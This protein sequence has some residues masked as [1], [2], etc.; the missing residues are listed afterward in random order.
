MRKEFDACRELFD[1][2]QRIVLSTHVNPDPDA[3]GSEIALAVYLRSRGKEVAILNHS[4]TPANCLFLDRLQSIKQFD[5]TLHAGIIANAD[6]IVVLDANQP[7]RIQSLRPFVDQSTATKICIDHH[8]E[9]QPFA[10]LYVV[11]EEAAATGEI[12]FNLLLYC[13]PG[14]ITE[15]IATALYA[16]IMTDTGSF[17]FPKTDADLHRIIAELIERGADPASIF[18]ET[19]EQGSAKRLQLLGNV[20]STLK[21]A[22]DGKV[23]SVFVTRAMF[24]NTGTTEED[25]ENFVTYALTIAGVE[26]AL[27]F[28]ELPDGIKIS[29]RS[30][31]DIAVNKLA[32][33][34]GGNG[35]RNAAGARTNQSG[36]DDLIRAVVERSKAYLV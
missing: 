9:R 13:H 24:R 23:A 19:Y 2:K 25:T 16:A 20:L 34:Y 11:D 7:D 15:E 36:L 35:H 8:L 17:R 10:D 27:M 3:I 28:T 1:A 30:R 12:L 6:L 29:F 22:H 4:A 21:V 5:P 18:H 26:I 32:Q 33:E 14:S 31:G